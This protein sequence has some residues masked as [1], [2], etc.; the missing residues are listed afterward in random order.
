MQHPSHPPRLLAALLGLRAFKPLRYRE[1]R[2]LWSGQIF[3]SMGMWME[4]VTRGWLI[5]ELTAWALQ[6]GRARGVQAIPYLLFSPL[7]GSAADRYSRK[8]Q[9]LMAQGATVLICGATALLVFAG[10]VRT[11]HV[12]VTAFL[13]A[14]AHVFQQ[15]VR[16][17]MI[18]DAVPREYLTNAIGLSSLMFNVSR[19]LG[20]ALAGALIVVTG[21]GG[22]FGVQALFLFL[23][24]A[25]TWPLLPVAHAARATSHRESVARSLA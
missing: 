12:Y 17:S 25:V 2:L 21:T 19:G 14:T 15:P 18:S 24:S 23:A 6:R 1:Y 4:E 20:P 3:G 7:A 22:A 9:L 8:T 13:A 16:A 5:S 10:L 11:W